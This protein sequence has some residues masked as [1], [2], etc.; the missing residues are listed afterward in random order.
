ME[1]TINDFSQQILRINVVG[2]RL[3]KSGFKDFTMK[4]EKTEFGLIGKG[5]ND[6]NEFLDNNLST[7]PGL[8]WFDNGMPELDQL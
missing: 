5:R 2:G 1:F 6:E 8:V 7:D 3:L 4:V